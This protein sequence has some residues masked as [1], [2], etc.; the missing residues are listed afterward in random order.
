[1]YTARPDQTHWHREMSFVG[2]PEMGATLLRGDPVVRDIEQWCMRKG[3]NDEVEPAL[4]VLFF[5]TDSAAKH[6]AQ[7]K[8]YVA[9]QVIHHVSQTDSMDP[10]ISPITDLTAFI[11]W[12]R[13]LGLRDAP[14]CVFGRGEKPNSAPEPG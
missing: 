8:A 1:M 2:S 7:I 10:S 13:L 6:Y 3:H 14:R 12:R 9:A 11:G 5:N 4:A